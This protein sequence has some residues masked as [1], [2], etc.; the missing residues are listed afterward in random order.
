MLKECIRLLQLFNNK[1]S[2]ERIA[3]LALHVFI[4][5]VLQKPSAKSKNKDHI[6]YLSKRL[7]W[8]K[9]GKIDDLMKE[10]KQIQKS[11]NNSKK[12]DASD[13]KGFTRLMLEGKIKQALKLIDNG[14]GVVGVHKLTD[15]IRQKLWEKHPVE[16]KTIRTI[17]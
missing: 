6:R 9:E 13:L 1:T 15:D 14:S 12:K 16:Q 10:G 11:I 8:W 2:W 4:P 17:Y 7:D 3:L 5:L